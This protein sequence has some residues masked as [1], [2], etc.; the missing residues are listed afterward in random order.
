MTGSAGFRTSGLCVADQAGSSADAS[1]VIRAVAIPATPQRVQVVTEIARVVGNRW[2]GKRM[3]VAK[4]APIFVDYDVAP[5]QPQCGL[6][7]QYATG[8]DSRNLSHNVNM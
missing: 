4:S 8:K 3:D 1:A 5:R 6:P 7:D 2:F